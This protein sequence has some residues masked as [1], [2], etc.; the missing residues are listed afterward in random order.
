MKKSEKI[1]EVVFMKKLTI[2]LLLVLSVSS[3]ALAQRLLP[4]D[5]ARFISIV[6]EELSITFQTI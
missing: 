2:L 3:I 6:T 4:Q 1:K 5:S